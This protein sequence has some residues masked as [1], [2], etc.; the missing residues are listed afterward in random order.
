MNSSIQK[1]DTYIL[2]Q[3]GDTYFAMNSFVV[4]QLD[5]V[6]AITLVPGAPEYV[7]GIVFSRGIVIPVVNLRLRLGLARKEHDMLTRL[8]IVKGKERHVGFIVDSA[9]DFICI[10]YESILP[11]PDNIAGLSGNYLEGIARLND[12]M[13]LVL[14]VESLLNVDVTDAK[15]EN[16]HKSEI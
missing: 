4:K 10:P 8:I 16:S 11:P 14:N 2:F 13:V 15:E 7:E 5:I 9:R 12:K 1:S 6:E 3:L